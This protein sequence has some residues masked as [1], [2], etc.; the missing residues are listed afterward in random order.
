M[1]LHIDSSEDQVS[2]YPR[3]GTV[4]PMST[5][6]RHRGDLS[7][8]LAKAAAGTFTPALAQQ[9][10]GLLRSS[11]RF[12]RRGITISGQGL[13]DVL[14]AAVPHLPVRDRA[15]IE[16]AHGGMTGEALA[17]RMIRAASRKS[18]VVGAV[19]GAV[20]TIDALAPPLWLLIPV[21][22]I[23][24]TMVVALIE[25]HLA[26]ELHNVFGVELLGE[27]SDRSKGLL[28]VWV[29]GRRLRVD[30]LGGAGG[31]QGGGLLNQR[32]LLQAV[33]RRLM[34]RMVRN[35]TSIAPWVGAAAGAEISRRATRDLG[36]RLVR[37][38][39]V[40]K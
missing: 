37:D 33:R 4:S 26:A 8:L 39:A 13:A 29:S 34:A 5:S 38:L 12:T 7:D 36:D 32:K 10:V 9:L 18:A 6:R 2:N 40:T 14:V 30:D 25:M 17:G 20:A 28:Q 21:D 23:I 35:M 1:S 11:V 22:V 16:A 15:T 19:A 27:G 3:S 24:E 31:L